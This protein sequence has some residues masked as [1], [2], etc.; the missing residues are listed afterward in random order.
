MAYLHG[1]PFQQGRVQES[2]GINKDKK[3]GRD[4]VLVEQLKIIGPKAKVAAGSAQQMIHGK[5]DPNHMET[6][7]EYRHTE[8][9]EILPFQ[10][11]INHIHRI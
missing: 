6:V 4:D 1:I 5:Y 10:R 11:V 2:N 3:A 7:P 9:W 8:A